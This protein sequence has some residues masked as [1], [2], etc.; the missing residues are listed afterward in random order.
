[1]TADELNVRIPLSA[2]PNDPR[3]RIVCPEGFGRV[4]KISPPSSSSSNGYVGLNVTCLADRLSSHL[5]VRSKCRGIRNAIQAYGRDHMT[6]QVVET[7]VPINVLRDREAYWVAHF[8][9][10][11]RGYNCTPG[12]DCNPMDDP[13]VR[14][15]HKATMSNPEFVAR[16][17]ATRK[18]VFATAEFKERVSI[19]HKVAWGRAGAKDKLSATLKKRWAEPGVRKKRGATMKRVWSNPEQHAR[20]VAAQKNAHKRPEVKL[21]KSE[22]SKRRWLDPVYRAKMSQM[23]K[24]E[25][26]KRRERAMASSV[27]KT[28]ISQPKERARQAQK[29]AILDTAPRPVSPSLLRPA[30][31]YPVHG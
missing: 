27:L 23:R 3:L 19:S 13:E 7:N 20:T 17:V 22:E 10:H 5:A 14:M 1:M 2:Y 4:Y 15:R 24:D 11:K 25:A 16:A 8:D 28:T 26:S 21:A 6:I 30:S 29:I 9:T 31:L 12:G 18:A